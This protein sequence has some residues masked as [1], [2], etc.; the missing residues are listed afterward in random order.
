MFYVFFWVIPLRLNFI[1]RRFG[2][3]C[4]FHL[5][6]QVGEFY[7]PTFRNA[8][9]VPSSQASRWI[10]IHLL[11][12]EGGT[13]WSETSAYNIQTP[14]NYPEENIQLSRSTLYLHLVTQ[15]SDA[16]RFTKALYYFCSLSQRKFSEWIVVYVTVAGKWKHFL[17]SI[18]AKLK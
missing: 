11:A 3:L 7:V 14:G 12:Y 15:K 8:L 4:L 9:S 2:T 10:I 18:W 16:V 1:C 13:E 5:H 17:S 6:R